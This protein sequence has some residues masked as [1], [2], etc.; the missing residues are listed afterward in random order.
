MEEMMSNEDRNIVKQA[1]DTCLAYDLL[2]EMHKKIEKDSKNQSK[3][4]Y[5]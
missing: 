1:N 2:C 5:P 4:L 3:D